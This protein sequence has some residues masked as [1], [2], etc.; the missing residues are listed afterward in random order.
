MA[1]DT[2][3]T[4]SLTPD[5]KTAQD[6]LASHLNAVLQVR[7]YANGIL[8]T[9]LTWNDSAGP[10][11]DWFTK[12]VADFT[13]AKTHA[14]TWAGIEA[15]MTS[16][17]PQQ[18]ID[19]GN[20]FTAATGDIVTLLTNDKF[21]PSA[22][23]AKTIADTLTQVCAQLTANG[24]AIGDLH[25][26][27]NVFSAGCA[28]DLATL[29]SGNN[30]IQK[31][32]NLEQQDVDRINGLIAQ[33][34]ADIATDQM[35]VEAAAIAAGVGLFVGVAAMALGA[36]T[37]GLGFFVGCFILAGAIAALGT[38]AAYMVKLGKAQ[39]ELID[40]QDSL[41]QDQQI[42]VALQLLQ[43]TVT[44]LVT[45]NKAVADAL[46][47]INDWFAGLSAK[48][49]SVIADMQ[50]AENYEAQSF[51]LMVKVEVDAGNAAW[52]QLIN[53]ATLYQQAVAGVDNQVVTP[54]AA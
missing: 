47:A 50:K 25:T 4:G 28:T 29:V 17:L 23:D 53:F 54:K 15:E 22:D 39:S 1:N 44:G 13:V 51:W 48:M 35:A 11:P 43:N 36:E 2:P 30:E 19:Y 52:A 5:T 18:L 3:A 27:F 7:A 37:M 40:E 16:T 33:T 10:A 21:K 31:A 45:Q 24:Q 34:N 41:G 12:L 32:L 8:A 38:M 20:L 26:R 9:N 46:D 6:N 49:N 14:G 42:I